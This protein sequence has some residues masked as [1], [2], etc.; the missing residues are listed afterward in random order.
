MTSAAPTYTLDGASGSAL[1]RYRVMANVVGY[2]LL[3][4]V[5][6]A[7]PLHYG[8]HQDALARVVAQIHGY[9]YLV[10]VVLTVDL[11]RRVGWSPLRTVLVCLAGTVP[12]LSFYVERRMT[13]YVVQR[14][15]G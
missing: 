8:F 12:F 9:S 1:T 3:V 6:I 14:S 11:A 13:Q 2:A 7:I 15:A 5:L 10:Y 4:L